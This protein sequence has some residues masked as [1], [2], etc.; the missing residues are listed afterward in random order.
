MPGMAE[1]PEELTSLRAQ[2]GEMKGGQFVLSWGNRALQTQ[3][4]VPMLEEY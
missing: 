4:D 2:A 3:G 1:T